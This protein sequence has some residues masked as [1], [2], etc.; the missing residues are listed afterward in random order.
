[1]IIVIVIVKGVILNK[2]MTTLSQGSAFF[3][4]WTFVINESGQ[5]RKVNI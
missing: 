4:K 1:M 5:H 2:A 3:A